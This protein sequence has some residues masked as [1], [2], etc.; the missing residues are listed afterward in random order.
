MM[1]MTEFTE[2]LTR[3]RLSFAARSVSGAQ[4]V[5]TERLS[6]YEAA[7]RVGCTRQAISRARKQ[8]VAAHAKGP[9]CGRDP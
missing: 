8:I 6:E 5:L 9:T 1:T 3:T 4:L 2:A 7:T